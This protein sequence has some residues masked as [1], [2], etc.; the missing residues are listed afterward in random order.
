LISSAA[1]NEPFAEVRNGN[2]ATLIVNLNAFFCF[3]N[4]SDYRWIPPGP[5]RIFPAVA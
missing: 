5:R 1:N 4:F 2:G 3:P